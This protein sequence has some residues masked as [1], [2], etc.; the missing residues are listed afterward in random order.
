MKLVEIDEKVTFSEQLEE[1]VGAVI[2]I[3]CD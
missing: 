3:Y 2:V 1:D